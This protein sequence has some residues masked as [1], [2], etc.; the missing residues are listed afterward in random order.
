M[1]EFGHCPG[2]GVGEKRFPERETT[3]DRNDA[4]SLFLEGVNQAMH[5]IIYFTWKN[6]HYFELFSPLK[7]LVRSLITGPGPRRCKFGFIL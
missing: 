6:V 5:A 2:F 3:H 4:K 7:V 1:N